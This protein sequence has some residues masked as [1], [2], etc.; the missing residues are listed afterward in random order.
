MRSIA[1]FL[2]ASTVC[3]SLG[4]CCEPGIRSVELG[5][6]PFI[7]GVSAAYVWLG[8]SLSFEA[9]AGTDPREFC[10]HQ[11]FTS[12]QL[13]NRFTYQSSNPSVATVSS[14]GVLVTHSL[15]VTNV[16]VM[17]SGVTSQVLPVIVGPQVAAIRFSPEPATIQVGDTLSVRIDALDN[18]GQVAAGAQL[19]VGLTDAPKDSIAMEVSVPRPVPPSF[20]LAT[21][22][23]VRFL[24]LRPG[25]A[26]LEVD[27][28]RYSVRLAPVIIDSLSIVV[29]PRSTPEI[30]RR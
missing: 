9:I 22:V 21:P 30:R 19:H 3:L 20:E 26:T 27:V 4:S 29:T 18:A 6:G 15:G 13:P 24:G 11:L 8:D 25:V 1:S 12:A 10:Y 14:L 28:P 16:A 7:A 23:T 2:L 5:I 17:T